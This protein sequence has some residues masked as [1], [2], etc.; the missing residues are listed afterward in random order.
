M[1]LSEN[2]LSAN[3]IKNEIYLMLLLVCYYSDLSYLLLLIQFIIVF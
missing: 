3:I 2:H 1:I